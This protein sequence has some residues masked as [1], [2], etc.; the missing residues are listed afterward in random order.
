[1]N[2]LNGDGND[3]Y[4]Q[5]NGYIYVGYKKLLNQIF[6]EMAIANTV[7][8]TMTVEQYNG[9]SWVELKKIDETNGLKKSGFIYFDEDTN[10]SQKT[11]ID[12]VEAVWYRI[13]F[14]VNHLNTSRIRGINLVFNNEHDMKK[15]EPSL[16]NYYPKNFNSHINSIL[17]A[18]EHILSMINNSEKKTYYYPDLYSNTNAVDASLFS[19][20][21]LF[22]LTEVKEMSSLLS[23]HFWYLNRS[24][25]NGGDRYSEMAE[26]YYNR[27]L[28]RFK[29]WSGLRLSLD[30]NGD[31]KED[32]FERQQSIKTVQIWR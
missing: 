5:T 4:M 28:E 32:N 16:S 6:I 17:A 18:R 9:S 25:A 24:D 23:C 26:H 1:M 19:Q 15:Y 20:F 22:D 8:N 21:D 7:N 13:K 30:R 10:N 14:S 3:F 11:T 29:M 27:F 2:D 12:G 31:G